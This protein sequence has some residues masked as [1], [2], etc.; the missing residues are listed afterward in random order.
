MIQAKKY[1]HINSPLDTTLIILPGRPSKGV[2]AL[3]QSACGNSF[4]FGE[5]RP[6]RNIR[7]LRRSDMIVNQKMDEG[8]EK[9][10]YTYGKGV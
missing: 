10:K 5:R 4:E 7:W 1:S 8:V 2:A 3:E 6:W 9:R